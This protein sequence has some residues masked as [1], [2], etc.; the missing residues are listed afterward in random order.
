MLD[1][2]IDV[3]HVHHIAQPRSGALSIAGSDSCKVHEHFYILSYR[4][5]LYRILSQGLPSGEFSSIFRYDLVYN[6]MSRWRM[7]ESE[8][9]VILAVDFP[10]WC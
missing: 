9:W 10:S 8:T 4:S 2:P 1:N 5:A 6:C 3:N 7:G